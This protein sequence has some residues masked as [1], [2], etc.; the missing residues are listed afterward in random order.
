MGERQDNNPI[1]EKQYAELKD[2]IKE[3]YIARG[4]V[5]S[6]ALQQRGIDTR[7]ERE[8]ADLASR[9]KKLE[10]VEKNDMSKLEALQAKIEKFASAIGVQFDPQ[11]GEVYFGAK[12]DPNAQVPQGQDLDETKDELSKTSREHSEVTQNLYGED[13][14]NPNF[15]PEKSKNPGIVAA[16]NQRKQDLMKRDAAVKK[17]LDAKVRLEVAKDRMDMH[18]ACHVAEKYRMM[19]LLEQVRLQLVKEIALGAK[20]N[21]LTVQNLKYQ[22]AGITNQIA[23][24]ESQ[25]EVERGS[26]S[27]EFGAAKVELDGCSKQVEYESKSGKDSKYPTILDYSDEGILNGSTMNGRRNDRDVEEK[28]I[29]D[30]RGVMIFDVAD[31]LAREKNVQIGGITVTCVTEFGPG[32]NV[33]DSFYIGEMEQL[34]VNTNDVRTVVEEM[35]DMQ[36]EIDNTEVGNTTT[37]SLFQREMVRSVGYM[38][39]DVVI[40]SIADK[41]NLPMEMQNMFVNAVSTMGGPQA[42]VQK[43]MLDMI[44]NEIKERTQDNELEENPYEERRGP[45]DNSN[46]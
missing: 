38:I 33:E 18:A 35:P 6:K 19:M 46:N 12:R 44:L 39:G 8:F 30:E 5:A 29:F 24:M 25:F 45:F 23:N 37:I 14:A 11:T 42:V 27:S 17:L 1:E 22:I 26:Y 21:D 4:T 13:I 20:E 9:Q 40:N 2:K 16:V 41:Q 7:D 28:E 36:E 34:E 3:W 10:D 15:D 43:A 31:V 32:S